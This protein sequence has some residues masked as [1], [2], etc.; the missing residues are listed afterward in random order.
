MKFLKNDI[1]MLISNRPIFYF[2]VL[3]TIFWIGMSV[4]RVKDR[5]IMRQDE[6]E[7]PEPNY[8][9]FY[10]KPNIDDLFWKRI[11]FI[12]SFVFVYYVPSAWKT[13]FLIGV[14]IDLTEHLSSAILCALGFEPIYRL[15][16]GKIEAAPG[17]AREDKGAAEASGL[18]AHIGAIVRPH[19]LENGPGVIASLKDIFIYN[20][21]G[22]ILGLLLTNKKY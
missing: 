16:Q 14:F 2:M 4:A 1:K 7:C 19:L 17:G 20:S 12:I 3:V 8:N 21:S 6:K 15:S 13:I 18:R 9:P 5:N 10:L 11:H 22:I